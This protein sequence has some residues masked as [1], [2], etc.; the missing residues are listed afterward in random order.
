MKYLIVIISLFIINCR[1]PEGIPGR[2]IKG[3]PGKN[4]VDGQSITGPQGQQGNPGVDATPVTIVPLCPGVSN[5]NV[6][7]EVG[8]CLNGK[9][10]GVYSANG[11][12]MTYLADGS[13][14]SNAI[15]SACNLTVNGCNVSH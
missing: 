2:D 15:G 4:G 6:F 5:H 8:I 12:F 11:G 3:D 10:Y 1:G 14:N 13:Y 9:L 7:V